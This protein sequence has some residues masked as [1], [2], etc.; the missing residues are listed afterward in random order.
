MK[1]KDEPDELTEAILTTM[2]LGFLEIEN[3]NPQSVRIL[4]HRR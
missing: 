3:I 4:E 1:L 2:T